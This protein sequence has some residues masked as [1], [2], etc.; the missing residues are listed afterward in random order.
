MK[1]LIEAMRT[2]TQVKILCMAN[3]DMPDS[4]AKTLVNMLEENQTLCTLN[5]ESNLLTGTVVADIVR[6]TLK[7]QTLIDLRL[8]NQVKICNFRFIN[9]MS[10]DFFLIKESSSV[11][12]QGR[13]GYCHLG[14]SE[15]H[16]V[17]VGCAF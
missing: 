17:E 6:A 5:I 8:S 9:S 12:K 3:I 15:W 11:R 4:V 16:V 14:G 7:N 1:R 13:D 10:N 2:N